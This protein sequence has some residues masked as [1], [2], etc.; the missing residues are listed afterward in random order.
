[1]RSRSRSPKSQRSRSHWRWRC[2]LRR[3]TYRWSR[4]SPC[5]RSHW[6]CWRRSNRP[7]HRRQRTRDRATGKET[8]NSLRLSSIPPS[9]IEVALGQLFRTLLHSSDELCIDLNHTTQWR[10]SEATGG[11]CVVPN[12]VRSADLALLLVIQ[13]HSSPR[14]DA[15][16]RPG[17]CTGTGRGRSASISRRISRNNS[18]GTAAAATAAAPIAAG[19]W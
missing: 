17:S 19:E 13:T 3:P 18:L 5:H 10:L 11:V 7:S 6:R 9:A 12:D 14:H 1:M 8:P 4:S 15:S 2:R 16:C